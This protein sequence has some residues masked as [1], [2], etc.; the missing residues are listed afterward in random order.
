MK[1]QPIAVLATSFAVSLLAFGAAPDYAAA[2]DPPERI[3][4]SGK[5][6]VRAE[7]K[8]FLETP[9]ARRFEVVPEVVTVKFKRSLT[10][11][12][13]GQ[14]LRT[15]NATKL[16]A[17]HLGVMDIKVPPGMDAVTFV[18]QLQ[19]EAD[20]DY[21]EVNTYG[22]FHQFIPD[23][24]RFDQLWGLDNTG[25]TGG[26]ADAD[27]DAPE[28]WDIATGTGNVIIAVIDTGIDRNHPDLANRIWSNPA[29]SPYNGIDDDGNG[30]VDDTWGW[31]FV[32]D[33]SDPD[34]YEPDDPRDDN[35]HGT[36]VDGI[37]GADSINGIGVAG[38]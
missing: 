17:N 11:T 22:E 12:S 24:T 29:E 14:F 31:N 35:G 18:A 21:A 13:R 33:V 1:L 16:R 28:A 32:S 8:W 4:L 27:I 2:A 36:H 19:Q 5:R 23:D 20:I 26:T 38:I 10:E 7:G 30:Y 3:E 37:A 15:R 6:F 34:D 25:Q 9:S